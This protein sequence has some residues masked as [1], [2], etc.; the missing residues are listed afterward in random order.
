VKYDVYTLAEELDLESNTLRTWLSN[1]RFNKNRLSGRPLSYDVT[2]DFL[3]TLE[4]YLCTKKQTNK[5][6]DTI[7]HVGFLRWRIGDEL[8]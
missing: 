4:N 7:R 1:Y 8:V 2:K 6:K 5:I 3:T